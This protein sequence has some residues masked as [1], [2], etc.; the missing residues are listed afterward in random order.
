VVDDSSAA[1]GSQQ[2]LTKLA[3]KIQHRLSKKHSSTTWIGK[4]IADMQAVAHVVKEFTPEKTQRRELELALDH[5]ISA[6]LLSP[7][8][9]PSDFR[10]LDDVL[11]QLEAASTELAQFAR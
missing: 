4:N 2:R 8:T 11:Q 1:L 7:A 5:F 10:R 3:T 9:T 6:V